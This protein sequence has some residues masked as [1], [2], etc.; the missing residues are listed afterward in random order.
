MIAMGT[1]TTVVYV[2]PDLLGNFVCVC[3]CI[4]K[5]VNQE[6]THTQ[7]LSTGNVPANEDIPSS[8]KALKLSKGPRGATCI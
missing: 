5:H 3:V 7:Y 1:L 4:V 2:M 8:I 6:Y